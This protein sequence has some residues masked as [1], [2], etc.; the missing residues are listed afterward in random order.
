MY[1]AGAL[2][3]VLAFIESRQEGLRNVKYEIFHGLTSKQK[4]DTINWAKEGQAKASND[5]SKAAERNRF[6]CF[7]INWLRGAPIKLNKIL[8]F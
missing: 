6:D 1:D 3:D 4:M 2:N 8:K 5:P 7:G